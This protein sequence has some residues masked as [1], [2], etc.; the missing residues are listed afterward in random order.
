MSFKIRQDIYKSL[1]ACLFPRLGIT[2]EIPE[3]SVHCQ[4]PVV[5]ICCQAQETQSLY[6]VHII[7]VQSVKCIDPKKY[8][9]LLL[10]KNV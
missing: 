8:N 1:C 6:H 2:M 5:D 9:L 4:I 3:I 7:S 10:N